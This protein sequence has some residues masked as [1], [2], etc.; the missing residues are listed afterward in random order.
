VGGERGRVEPSHPIG[1]MVPGS[2]IGPPASANGIPDSDPRPGA[3]HA[4]HRRH[5]PPP[6][7]LGHALRGQ[8]PSPS[9]PRPACR[10]RRAPRPPSNARRPARSACIRAAPAD[11]IPGI[12][13]RPAVAPGEL[14]PRPPA[15][16]DRRRTRPAARR[17]LP[18]RRRTM[19]ALDLFGHPRPARAAAAPRAPQPAPPVRVLHCEPH[20]GQA[21]RRRPPLRGRAGSGPPSRAG[22]VRAAP[23]LQATAGSARPSRPRAGTGTR[24]APASRSHPRP[25]HRRRPGDLATRAAPRTH[26]AGRD[27]VR[28]TESGPTSTAAGRVSPRPVSLGPVSLGRRRS[29]CRGRR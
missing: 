12:P 8:H 4:T 7:H 23:E 13:S 27:R 25:R 1:M 2:D 21:P 15:A 6:H 11:R 9:A 20:P 26:L 16:G 17:R 28:T 22:R 24:P 14:E 3:P 29:P 19:A 18:T 5:P 10:A